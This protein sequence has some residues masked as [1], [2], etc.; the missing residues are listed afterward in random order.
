MYVLVSGQ[1]DKEICIDFFILLMF[2]VSHRIYLFHLWI[3]VYFTYGSL[4]LLLRKHFIFFLG[5]MVYFTYGSLFI[6]LSNCVFILGNYTGWTKKLITVLIGSWHFY[7]FIISLY[8]DA[9]RIVCVG[10][11]SRNVAILMTRSVLTLTF[12]P[13]YKFVNITQLL[14]PMSFRDCFC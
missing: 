7:S 8:V 11:G 10:I 14:L 2:L 6:L 13:L 12:D 4:F 3:V 9:N 5:I 1:T